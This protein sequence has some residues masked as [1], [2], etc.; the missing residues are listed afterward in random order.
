MN[1]YKNALS[2][3][4][5]LKENFLDEKTSETLF[6]YLVFQGYKLTSRR[7]VMYPPYTYYYEIVSDN[8]GYGEVHFIPD[9]NEVKV[10][11]YL[12]DKRYTTK[13][14]TLFIAKERYEYVVNKA[15]FD[16]IYAHDDYKIVDYINASNY[17]NFILKKWHNEEVSD[18]LV[19]LREYLL[20]EDDFDKLLKINRLAEDFRK[21]DSNKELKYVK[22]N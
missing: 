13:C 8:N 20:D 2:E 11:E 15:S 21:R 1:N 3:F 5:D 9:K 14:L 7:G 4:F 6:N 18:D 10:V 19:A 16:T 12:P 22:Q 17:Q